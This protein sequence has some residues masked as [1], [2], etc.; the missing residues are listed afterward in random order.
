[1]FERAS[2]KLGLEQAVLTNI[3]GTKD[4]DG[5]KG[6][7]QKQQMDHTDIDKLLKFGVW[8]SWT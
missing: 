5:E 6:G 7:E 3:T 8:A 1:M 4:E 2:L